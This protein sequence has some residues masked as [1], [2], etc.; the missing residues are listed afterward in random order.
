MLQNI[1]KTTPKF[2]CARR[3]LVIYII[4]G[5]AKMFW[6]QCQM[7]LG[8]ANNFWGMQTISG[9][10][11][12]WG[13]KR[14]D[15]RIVFQNFKTYSKLSEICRKPFLSSKQWHL[16]DKKHVLK[17][18]LI[19]VKCKQP[20]GQEILVKYKVGTTGNHGVKKGAPQQICLN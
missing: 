7:P 8:D 15:H 13:H 18:F 1:L 9:G 10:V 11:C 3:A 5:G 4:C 6:A 12:T 17:F 16:I 19:L 20:W 14:G 2:F